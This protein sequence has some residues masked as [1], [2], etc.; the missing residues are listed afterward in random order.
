MGQMIHT[1]EQLRPYIQTLM[2]AATEHGTPVMRPVWFEFPDDPHAATSEVETTQFMLGDELLVAPVT[3]FAS[4]QRHV[5]LPAGAVWQHYFTG[6]EFQGGANVS[7]AVPID[8]PAV[9]KRRPA[10]GS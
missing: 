9:L 2:T 7:M 3:D 10:L 6:E 1:R 4:R 5:Y 8:T